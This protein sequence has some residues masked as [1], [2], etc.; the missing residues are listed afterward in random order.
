LRGGGNGTMPKGAGEKR[1][2]ALVQKIRRNRGPTITNGRR[3]TGTSPPGFFHRKRKTRI[4]LAAAGRVKT[5]SYKKIPE[6]EGSP[7]PKLTRGTL[8]GARSQKKERPVRNNE[9]QLGTGGKN[10]HKLQ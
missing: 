10:R 7:N 5:A 6:T 2:N 9:S 1:E 3:K 8:T 4:P